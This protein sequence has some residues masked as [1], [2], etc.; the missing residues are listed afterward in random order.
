VTGQTLPET[1]LAHIERWVAR[2][3][4]RIPSHAAALVRIELDVDARHVTI[5]ECRPPWQDEATEA[6][7]SRTPVAQLRYTAT[8]R[9]WALYWPDSDSKFHRYGSAPSTADVGALL[10]EI[11]RDETSIFWG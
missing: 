7:W 3:N 8:R 5:F 4:D 11:D 2:E 1:D 10:D 9:E 6:E